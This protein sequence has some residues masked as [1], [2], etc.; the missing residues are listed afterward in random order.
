MSNHAPSLPGDQ[1]RS[2]PTLKLLLLS[3]VD[4]FRDLSQE[5][6]QAIEG[7]GQHDY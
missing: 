5:E 4:I 6:M 7:Y 3:E 1:T 2:E